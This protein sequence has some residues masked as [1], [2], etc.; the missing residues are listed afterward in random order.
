[1]QMTAAQMAVT[2]GAVILGT[3]LTR[4]LPYALFPEGK[5]VP[6]FVRYLGRVLGPAVFGLLVVYCL[7]QTDWMTPFSA[8]GTHGIPE[9]AATAVTILIFVWKRQMILSMASGT[10]VYMVLVQFV[11]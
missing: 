8:G 4:F 1:M 9:I 6:E 5:P 11:F 7:R 2:I 10:V 3:V